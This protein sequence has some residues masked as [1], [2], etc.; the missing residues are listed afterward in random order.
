MAPS[1]CTASLLVLN[2]SVQLFLLPTA[3]N[4]ALLEE[5][6]D[7]LAGRVS[8]AWAGVG[9]GLAGWAS[10]LALGAGLPGE[11]ERVWPAMDA[12]WRVW[13]GDRWRNSPEQTRILDAAPH[14]PSCD[15]EQKGSV[16]RISVPRPASPEDIKGAKDARTLMA[17][18]NGIAKKINALERRAALRRPASGKKR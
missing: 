14:G 5:K 11:L 15:I 18:L 7:S 1:A 4:A 9:Y 2:S 17:S 6:L 13:I 8:F 16:L 12:D 10:S 3:E